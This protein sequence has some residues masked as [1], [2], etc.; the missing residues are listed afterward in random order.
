MEN[1]Y[2]NKPSDDN[3][4]P[5]VFS[6]NSLKSEIYT[7]KRPRIEKEPVD[8]SAA[9]ETFRDDFSEQPPKKN[10]NKL[11]LIL[12]C[13]LLAVLLAGMGVIVYFLLNGDRGGKIDG[14][15]TE[16]PFTPTEAPKTELPASTDVPETPVL[17]EAPT[18]EPTPEPTP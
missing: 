6:Q 11:F 8:D 1:P 12:M 14:A 13:V 4:K 10:G 16:A 3:E 18:A 2:F 9:D 17:T 7:K 15:A 5:K